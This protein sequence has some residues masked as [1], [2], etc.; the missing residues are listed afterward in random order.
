ML[1]LKEPKERKLNC[2]QEEVAQKAARKIIRVQTR[3]AGWLNKRT[4]HFTT[5]Q[6]HLLLLAISAIFS[7]ISLYL[8]FNSFN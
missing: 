5:A 6:K 2:H 1:F 4:E 8:I 7:G 3:L